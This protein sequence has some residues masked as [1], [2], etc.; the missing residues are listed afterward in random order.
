LFSGT[1]FAQDNPAEWNKAWTK[2]QTVHVQETAG[3]NRTHEPVEA[4]IKFYQPMPGKDVK[5]IESAVR[6]GVRVIHKTAGGQW[7]EIPSQV[8]DIRPYDWNRRAQTPEI[9]V[10]A[11]VAFFADVP[12]N[13]TGTYHIAYGNSTAPEPE[14]PSSLRVTGEGVGYTIDNP[15]FTMITDK[16][17][18]QI[19][20]MSLKFSGNPSFRFP[21]GNM[22]W[23]PDFMYTPGDFPTT[24]FKWFYAHHFENPPH[25][26]VSGPIFFSQRRS[27]LVPGQDIAWMEVYYR[28]YDGLP[29]FLMESRI[30]TK[31]KC[32]TLA[33]RNDEIAF[34]SNDFTHAGW[35][36]YT[37]DMLPG[38]IGEIGSVDVF[39]EARM[40]NHVLGSALPANI[41]WISLCHVQKGYAAG[42]IRLAW[43]NTN[44]LSGLPSPIYNSHTVI[45]EHGGGLYWFR[46]LVY[47][48]RDDYNDL[49][50]D[51]DDW[52]AACHEIPEGSSYYEKNAY[53]F[54]EWT[55]EGKFKPIDDLWFKLRE[56]LKVTLA[57]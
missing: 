29:Y 46:S 3:F 42:S 28:F 57:R 2:F 34:G 39:N 44:V 47:S 13:M 40:G 8:Y 49:G 48:Q 37:T 15:F 22:H 38:H 21:A 55:K 9:M 53:V 27:Q 30:T 1:P 4:E 35:R 50:W 26:T 36:N 51:A 45:S 18:G 11:R 7:E 52:R 43:D 17:S 12:A 31:K 5:G 25:E 41:P 54:Y 32:H 23:N 56:P 14:Y 16:K 33:I 6:K 24:W 10:R 20:R 19:D